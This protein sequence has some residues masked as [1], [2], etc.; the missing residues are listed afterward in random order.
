MAA[1]TVT[2]RRR[3]TAAIPDDVDAMLTDLQR[4]TLRQIDSFGWRLQFV[5]RPL[6]QDVTV[7]V[8]HQDSGALAVLDVDGHLDKESGLTPRG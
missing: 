2:E 8:G 4:M 5:R 1:K 6:F 7:V 3:G